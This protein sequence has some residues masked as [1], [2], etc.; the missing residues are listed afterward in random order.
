MAFLSPKQNKQNLKLYFPTLHLFQNTNGMSSTKNLV[1]N[2]IDKIEIT[3]YIMLIRD[4]CMTVILV[5][6]FIKDIVL[7]GDAVCDT[8]LA[9]WKTMGQFDGGSN[10]DNGDNN[11]CNCS[12][13]F[14]KIHFPKGEGIKVITSDDYQY[15]PDSVYIKP[16]G[17]DKYQQI[18]VDEEGNVRTP[19]FPDFPDIPEINYPVEDGESSGSGVP[20]Y[21]GLFSKKIRIANLKTD[22]LTITE[23]IDGNVKIN[24]PESG[25]SSSD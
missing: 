22:N 2:A 17:T 25:S 16:K 19:E 4:E 13:D 8:L 6:D 20:L 14:V 15:V 3:D 18:V 9:C 1:K 5:E 23:D 11:D 12:E 21:K 10:P 7:G 24:Y